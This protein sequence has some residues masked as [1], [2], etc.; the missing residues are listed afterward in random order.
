MRASCQPASVF[1]QADD[2]WAVDPQTRPNSRYGLQKPSIKPGKHL[3]GYSLLLQ[4]HPDLRVSDQPRPDT[5]SPYSAN[6]VAGLGSRAALHNDG[7]HPPRMQQAP[8]AARL[9][10]SGST[11]TMPLSPCAAA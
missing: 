3:V 8:L 2:H 4:L 1:M 6:P 11:G 10:P 9:A 7:Q 5:E